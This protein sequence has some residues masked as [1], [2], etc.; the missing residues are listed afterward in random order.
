MKGYKKK[1]SGKLHA[2]CMYMN[3]KKR[4]TFVCNSLIVSLLFLLDLNQG[5]SD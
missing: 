2:N 1:Q 3:K 4:A 5:P